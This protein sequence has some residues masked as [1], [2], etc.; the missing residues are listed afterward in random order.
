MPCG[1]DPIVSPPDIED[2]THGL[3]EIEH[4]EG[5]LSYEFNEPRKC[6]QNNCQADH[7][8][9]SRPLEQLPVTVWKRLP[10]PSYIPLCNMSSNG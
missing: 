10:I 3:Q 6:K 4:E 1:D 7:V 9:V 2:T 8:D 5:E